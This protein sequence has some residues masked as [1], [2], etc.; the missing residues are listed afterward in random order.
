MMAPDA[1]IVVGSAVAVA[2][3]EQAVDLVLVEHAL[4]AGLGALGGRGI[5]HAG[6]LAAMS[7]ATTGG[8]TPCSASAAFHC[9][10]RSR[11]PAGLSRAGFCQ[12]GMLPA[13]C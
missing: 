6:P 12:V 2:E 11:R 4:A 1:G 3:A 10:A 7:S 5:E 8:V 9:S 13:F